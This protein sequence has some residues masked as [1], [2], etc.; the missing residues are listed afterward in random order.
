M[1]TR[2]HVLKG[3]FSMS[4]K[5]KNVKA[6]LGTAAFALMFGSVSVHAVGSAAGASGGPSATGAGAATGAQTS[7]T[8][9][10][11]E[12]P[13]VFGMS[14]A[15]E[16]MMKDLATTNMAEIQAAKIALDRSKDEQ[17][18]KFAQKML[19]DHSKAHEKVQDLA[20]IK[21][22][23]L[24]ADLDGRHQAEIKKLSNLSGDKFDKAYLER[25]GVSDHKQAMEL[26]ERIEKRAKDPQLQAIAT[27]LK[28]TI[29]EHRQMATQMVKS[30][31]AT[32]SGSPDGAMSSAAGASSPG[33]AS[34]AAKAPQ[35][36]GG[37]S[38][39]ETKDASK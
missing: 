31:A 26:L 24:P 33:S 22:V 11:G 36:G 16:K 4:T 23:A 17:V 9:A 28:P 30:D 7:G 13:K 18:Q 38:R 6:L 34:D 15:D 3:E 25:A 27:D 2:H 12:K 14:Q 10:A 5:Q 29:R 19:E 32:T 8:T 1:A 20:Q 37:S 35:Q 39:S 21:N